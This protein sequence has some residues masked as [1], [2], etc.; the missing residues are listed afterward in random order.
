MATLSETA[1]SE[2]LLEFLSR[3]S[4]Y[5]VGTTAV[6]RMETHISWVFLTD[7]HAYKLKKPVKFEFLDFSTPALRQWAC[8]EELRLN[9]RLAP[10]VYLSILPITQDDG[11]K[12][13]LG[14]EGEPLDWL[15]KMKRLPADRA[16]DV[17]LRTKKLAFDDATWIAQHLARWYAGLPPAPLGGAEYRQ[18]LERHVRANGAA[19][20]E[21]LP[22]DRERVGR[23]QGAQLRLLRVHA[24]LFDER[25]ERGRVVEGHGDL[26]PEH[27]Y[28]TDPP[29]IIDCIEFSAE[30][31]SV[32]IAD[33]L[34]FLGMECRRLG[35]GGLGELALA[36]YERACNDEVPRQLLAFYRS[37]RACVRAKVATLR[38]RQ[39]SEVE[40]QP[41]TRLT[42]HYLNWA[43][44]YAAEMGRPLLLV[45]GG[46]MGTG[47]S[48]L[49]G[50]LAE[51]LGAEAVSTDQVRREALGPSRAPAAYAEGI[52]EPRL[53]DRVYESLWHEAGRRLCRGQSVVLDGTFLSQARREV[54]Y[55][56]GRRHR[57][58]P[59]FVWCDCP[60]QT[61][62]ARIAERARQGGNA[63]EA[64]TDLYDQQA[65]ELDPPAAGEPVVKVDTTRDLSLE[66]DA[67]LDRL[68]RCLEA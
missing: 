66:V 5:P 49:A 20:V 45:V 57:V 68:R 61:A 13:Q 58:V 64:R 19:L 14:G 38:S 54:A 39:V 52:Y 34:C 4:S 27:I 65:A 42:H 11:G 59:L 2:A 47:K 6:Q 50:R 37:Y 21:A 56:L 55:E 9:R 3:A 41:L 28:L 46:L 53:R 32:D 18:M 33:E 40:R 30:L 24:D 62:L 26:R 35:D 60:R 44:H 22:A 15:V 23:I 31:R 36:A 8:E 63:S 25:V 7:E 43:D 1:G 16:V 10:D 17:L 12:L 29:A 51:A 67:V 48:S